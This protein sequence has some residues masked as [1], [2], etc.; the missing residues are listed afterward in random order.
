MNLEELIDTW[1]IEDVVFKKSLAQY[2]GFP[3]IFNGSVPDDK[4]EGWDGKSQYPRICYALDFQVN[5][6]RSSAGTMDF[7]IYCESSDERLKAL[8]NESKLRLQDVIMRPENESPYC[9][10]WNSTE[11]FEYDK[12][13]VGID[14]HFDIREFPS[15]ETT[16]PDPIMAMNKF[17]KEMFENFIVLG[18]DKIDDYVSAK[19]SP[20][21]Y[22]SLDNQERGLE[23]NSV[24]WMNCKIAVH[25]LCPKSDLRLKVITALAKNLSLNGEVIMLD[26]SPMTVQRLQQNNKADYLTEGQ[27]YV[28]CKYGLLRYKSKPHRITE[29]NITY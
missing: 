3:A 19:D 20:L 27:L 12:G 8:E 10:T 17:I 29:A 25:F 24:V 13:I 11:A 2:G 1:L 28:A 4:Q 18:W 6:E 15:Q 9:F 23:T 14:L 16:D 21:F 5:P 26:D 22:C 7:A